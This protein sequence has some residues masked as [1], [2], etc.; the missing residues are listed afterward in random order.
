V[1]ALS[2]S[3]ILPITWSTS[4]LTPLPVHILHTCLF[5]PSTMTSQPHPAHTPMCPVHPLH[6]HACPLM[7]AHLLSTHLCMW[8]THPCILPTLHES[9]PPCV[10]PAHFM[11]LIPASCGSCL[12]HTLLPTILPASCVSCLPPWF[13]PALCASHASFLHHVHH[14]HSHLM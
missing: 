3:H 2:Y 8:P 13:Q 11:C 14:H 6:H 9:Y 5:A 10:C 7:H 1:Q 12:C 4:T